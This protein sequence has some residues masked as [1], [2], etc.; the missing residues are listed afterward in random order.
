MLHKCGTSNLYLCD[1]R[2][3]FSSSCVI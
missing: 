1:F 3:T 2:W